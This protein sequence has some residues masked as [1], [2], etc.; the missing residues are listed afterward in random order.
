MIRAVFWD[1]GNVL[2][3]WDVRALYRRIFDD[4]AE[5]ERFLDAV[6]TPAHNLRCDG[7][8]PFDAVI[9]EV[10]EQHPHYEAQ[11]R[12][13]KDRWI[14][15]VPGPVPGMVELLEELRSCGYTQVGITNFSAETFPLVED[16]PALRLLDDVVV[17]GR[18]GVRK[19]DPRIYLEA[20]RLARVDAGDA[21]FVDD[22]PGN[23]D[24]ARRVG[25]HAIHFVDAAQLRAGLGGLGAPTHVASAAPEAHVT[26]GGGVSGAAIG[27]TGPFPAAGRPKPRAP[28]RPDTT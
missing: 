21:V 26:G 5:M 10:V 4:P 28:P 25:M 15:T 23:V 7:G 22:S 14:E 16:R 24:G 20:L 12:A 1:V 3:R 2:L 19:P 13:A 9:A 6:W 17:S 8:E 27:Q 18:T 11:V